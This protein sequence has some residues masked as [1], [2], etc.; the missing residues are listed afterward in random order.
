VA[1]AQRGL[2][3]AFRDIPLITVRQFAPETTTPGKTR[4]VRAYCMEV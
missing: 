2:S 3:L 4:A 1:I